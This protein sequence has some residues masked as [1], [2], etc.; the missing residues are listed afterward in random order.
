[1]ADLHILLA[2]YAKLCPYI[3]LLS[4]FVKMIGVYVDRIVK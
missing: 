2:I 4:N 1:M 3:F